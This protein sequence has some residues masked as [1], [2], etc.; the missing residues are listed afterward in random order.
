MDT[1]R[2]QWGPFRSCIQDEGTCGQCP[3]LAALTSARE[4]LPFPN[5]DRVLIRMKT[6][7][8]GGEF[9]G[10]SVTRLWATEDPEDPDFQRPENE[11]TFERLARLSGWRVGRQ[12]HDEISSAFWMHRWSESA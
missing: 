1:R 6:T 10:V 11:W 4:E 8:L 7:H 2:A 3:V 9:N 12:Y 5:A